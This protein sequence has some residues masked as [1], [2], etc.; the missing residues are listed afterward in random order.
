VLSRLVADGRIERIAR[1]VYRL[2]SSAI[3]E[4]HG[5]AVAA[6]ARPHGVKQETATETVLQQAEVLSAEWVP[7]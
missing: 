7:S 3:T 1:R 5:L 4:S 6:A 2:L